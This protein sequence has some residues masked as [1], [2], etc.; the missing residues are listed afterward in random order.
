MQKVPHLSQWKYL[1]LWFGV[2]MKGY[3]LSLCMYTYTVTPLFLPATFC[4]QLHTDHKVNFIIFKPHP[5]K[6]LSASLWFT[7]AYLPLSPQV[8]YHL[9]QEVLHKTSGRESHSPVC[10]FRAHIITIICLLTVSFTS[11]RVLAGVFYKHY[12]I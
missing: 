10:A 3:F 12:F 6:N 1:I 4:S 9:C 8:R 2:V 11:L 7:N 5:K